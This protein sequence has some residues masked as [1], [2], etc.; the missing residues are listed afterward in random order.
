M[1]KYDRYVAL[2]LEKGADDALIVDTAKIFTAPWVRMKCRFGCLY[3]G[4]KLCCPPRT[5]DH[6][7]TRLFLDSYKYA[8]LCHKHWIKDYKVVDTFN[9][10]IVD[11]ETAIFLDGY[12]KALGLG[13]GPCTLCKA[14]DAGGTCRNPERARPAMEACGIDVFQTARAHGL[15]IRVVRTHREERDIYGIVLI[16]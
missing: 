5:P 4:Q 16:E 3:Y 6:N 10:A 14:C 7:E 15:P 11:L 2:A 9:S 1:K 12:Y 8:L 13:M